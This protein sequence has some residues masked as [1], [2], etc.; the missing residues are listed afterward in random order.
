MLAGLPCSRR[1]EIVAECVS[2]LRLRSFPNGQGMVLCKF[3]ASCRRMRHHDLTS[4]IG[5]IVG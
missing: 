4:H 5:L 2:L 1:L 3:C